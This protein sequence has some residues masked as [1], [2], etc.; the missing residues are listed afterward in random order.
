MT[1]WEGRELRGREVAALLALVM[2]CVVVGG[3]GL[4]WLFTLGVEWVAGGR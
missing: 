3:T 4:L 2:F 1:G